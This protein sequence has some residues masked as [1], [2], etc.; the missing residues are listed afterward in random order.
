MHKALVALEKKRVNRGTK[1]LDVWVTIFKWLGIVYFGFLFLALGFGAYPLINES[2]PD[3]NPVN[4][5]SRYLTYYF[6]VELVMRF[7]MQ[8][9][10]TA[11]IKPLL[12]LNIPRK[13]I[14]S[15][16]VGKTFL[17]PFNFIQLLFLVPFAIACIMNEE[18]S[19]QIILWI[20]GIYLYICCMHFVNILSESYKKV[21]YSIVVFFIL[22]GF[23]QYYNLF[24][25]TIYTQYV[26]LSVYHYPFLI[27]IPL[28]LLGILSYATHR[29]YL[30]NLYL[31]NLMTAKVE[32]AKT[33]EMSWLDRFGTHALFLKN[34]IRL[35][36][37][38]KRAK[39]T[40][41]LS[42]LFLFYGFL[43]LRFGE[44]E[45]NSIYSL[46]FV[47]FFVS[48]GFLMLYGQYVP[49]WDSSYYPLMMT[50]N[51]TYK[52]YLKSKWLIIALGT[53]LSTLFCFFYAF[54]DM[55]L[56]YLIIA[57][58]I[59]NVG[60]NGYVVLW[61]GAY[62]KSPMDLT[63]NKNVFGDK[64]AFNL[65]VMLISLPKVI[66][67]IIL[68]VIGN[69]IYAFWGGIAVLVLVG[70]A[71]MFFQKQAF[72]YIEKIYKKEKYDT[73]KSFKENN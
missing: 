11:N 3:E 40:V 17:S 51:I 37:R 21:F 25:V 64:N 59:F 26:F 47:A 54:F 28:L 41:L 67:P 36:I 56:F 10:P 24:D 38:N 49:S 23:L 35:I 65:K 45:T 58:G 70:I 60:I 68:F 33:Q 14:V 44:G 19:A 50:Q 34:D 46:V 16:F 48:G 53:L 18:N 62:M 6:V 2:F 30:S 29:Y 39:T 9:L 7:L 43:L 42:V 72:G 69:L 52:N 61:G 20:T 57:M 71:G 15:F 27:I 12:I 32:E 31:D 55:N 4:F 73:L 22:G 8:K 66:L 13:K 1:Q 5:I 63:A